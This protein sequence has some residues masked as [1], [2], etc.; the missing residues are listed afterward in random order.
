MSDEVEHKNLGPLFAD[1]LAE[2]GLLEGAEA[3]AAQQ[4]LARRVARERR[5]RGIFRRLWWGGWG[6]LV[7]GFGGFW[8]WVMRGLAR[9]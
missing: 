4:A 7:R 6:F 8:G 9:H 5:E 1:F 2:E 3:Y